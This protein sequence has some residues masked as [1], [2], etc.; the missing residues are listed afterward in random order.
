MSDVQLYIAVG[1]PNLL[2]GATIIIE[3]RWAQ[4]SKLKLKVC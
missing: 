4:S 1:L 3:T 2:N